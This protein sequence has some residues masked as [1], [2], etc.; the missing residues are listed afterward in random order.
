MAKDEVRE[1]GMEPQPPFKVTVIGSGNFGTTVAKLV[2][3]NTAKKKDFVSQVNMWVF[4]E[5]V[6]GKNLSEIINTKHENV[7][8][9]PGVTLPDNVVAQPDLAT[10]CKDSNIL[11]FVVPHQF[12]GKLL[13][14][15]KAN[16]AADSLACTLIKGIEFDDNGIILLSEVIKTALGINVSVL[17]GANV[18]SE[19]AKGDFA[20]ATIGGVLG[21]GNI[22]KQIFQTPYFRVSLVDNAPAVELCGAF[23]NIVALGAG[24]CDGLGFGNNTK[25]AIIRIG[26]VEMGRVIEQHTGHFPTEILLESAGVADLITTCYGGRNR[27]CAEAFVRTKKDWATIEAEL[28]G[29]QKLQGTLTSLEL[30]KVLENQGIENQFPLFKNIYDIAFQG[31]DPKTIV[32]G[33]VEEEEGHL[34]QANENHWEITKAKKSQTNS[35]L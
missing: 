15:I 8:Y 19:I 10:A 4:E 21:N 20:E 27:K 14:V 11:L 34:I 31:A 25:A 16:M 23:K 24:F 17:M 1:D 22:L 29:G 33:L 2:A 26:M 9:L 12:L 35:R 5:K 7:K 13:P 3:E 18:A 32:E 6:D 30:H 28:L